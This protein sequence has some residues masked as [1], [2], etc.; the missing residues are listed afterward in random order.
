MLEEH[1]EFRYDD[2]VRD[3]LILLINVFLMKL[4]PIFFEF[5]LTCGD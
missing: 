5:E 3:S 2:L 4:S 1:S